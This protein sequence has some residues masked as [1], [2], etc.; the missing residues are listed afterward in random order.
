MEYR[1]ATEALFILVLSFMILS[2]G[3]NSGESNNTSSQVHPSGVNLGGVY[4]LEDWFFSSS[5]VDHYVATPCTYKDTGIASSQIFAQ[6]TAVP[7][8]TWTSE[9]QMIQQFSAQGYTDSQIAALF[10]SHRANYLLDPA[11]HIDNLNSVFSRIRAL[12]I[13][14]VRLPITWAITYPTQSYTINPGNGGSPIVVPATTQ[15]TLIQ[16]PFYPSL[17]WAS[18]PIGQVMQVLKVASR[19]GIK[20]LLDIHA[21]PGGSSDGTFNG[22]WPLQPEFWNT[23]LDS[24]NTPIYQDNFQTIFQNLITWAE[25]LYTMSDKTYAAGLGGLTAMN[26]P[27]HLM[28]IPPARCTN[29]SWGITS[30]QD[31]LDTLALAVK[32]FGQSSLPAHNVKLYMNVIET[33]FP[34]TMTGEQI[35][36]VIGTWWNSI[37][38]SNDRQTW[39]VLDLHH[40]FAWDGK[41]NSC[42][43]NYVTN[44]VIQQAG[45]DQMKQCSDDWYLTIREKLGLS[46]MDRFATTEF[47]ASANSDT[48]QS[49]ASGNAQPTTPQ[50]YETYRNAVLQYQ[51]DDAKQ[52][53]IDLY[54]WT[55]TIPYNDNFQHE[56]SLTNI[57]K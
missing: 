34:T 54:F 19:H 46:S 36:S 2:C 4:V 48:Y 43:Q 12:G 57:L 15:V 28:G 26:E 21:Y 33:M 47:S 37:T 7:N 3:G 9:T 50:N 5:E 22:I 42:L 16:D 18:V 56:W 44:G 6:S 13:R 51:I 53:D 1:R 23:G 24:N 49:C 45:F 27:A 11:N 29:G 55:W 39:A 10:T 38:T 8:F 52:A 35:Y 41:C 17:K 14:E 40:Y 20:V 32:D 31:V 30:Y 25:S